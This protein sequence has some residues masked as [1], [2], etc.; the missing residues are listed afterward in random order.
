M[1]EFM[2]R[3]NYINIFITI[4]ILSDMKFT[5]MLKT[6]ESNKQTS[7]GPGLIPCQVMWDLW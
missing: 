2:L 6:T 1:F 5:E 4:Y 3:N 7:G